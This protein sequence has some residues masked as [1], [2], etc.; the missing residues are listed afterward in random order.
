MG[1]DEFSS[2]FSIFPDSLSS[3]ICKEQMGSFR[4]TGVI[5][6][7][8]YNTVK[9]STIHF[10]YLYFISVV[11]YLFYAIKVISAFIINF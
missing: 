8:S 2:A 3:M 7:H 1:T 9:H 6:S 5:G 4:S 10:N 11:C